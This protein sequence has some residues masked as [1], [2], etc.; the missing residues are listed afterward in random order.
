MRALSGDSQAESDLVGIVSRRGEQTIHHK[1]VRL[2]ADALRTA[3]DARTA[4]MPS[5]EPV[6]EPL[7]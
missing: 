1:V 3:R 2:A 5:Y 7:M 6:S 4:R